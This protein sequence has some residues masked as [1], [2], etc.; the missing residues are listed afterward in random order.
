MAVW[1]SVFAS[2]CEWVNEKHKRALST[3]KVE[4]HHIS[5]DQV[6]Q[7]SFPSV[8]GKDQKTRHITRLHLQGVHSTGPNGR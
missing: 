5:V 1:P 4:T 2:I 7:Q 6:N 3:I 8:A